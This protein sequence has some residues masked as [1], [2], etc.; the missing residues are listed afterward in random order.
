[1]SAILKHTFGPWHRH[2]PHIHARYESATGIRHY[3][4]ADALQH[5][6]LAEGESEAN[7]ALIEAAPDLLASAKLALLEIKQ[8]HS[9]AYPD[10]H[11]ERARLGEENWTCPAHEAMYKLEA[12]IKKAEG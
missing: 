3:A 12:A 4:V 1:M 7:A 8:F 9:T 5:A 10:C 2:G 11:K 6:G